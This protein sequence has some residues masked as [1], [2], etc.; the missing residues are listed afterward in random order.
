[1]VFRRLSVWLALAGVLLTIATL[2]GARDKPMAPAPMEPPPRNPYASTVAAAGI[3][4]AAN[5]NVKIAPPV[6]GLVTK[7]YVKVASQVHQGDVLFQLDDRELRAQLQT[8]TD[9][10]PSAAARIAEQD[11]RLRDVEDQ[12]QRLQSVKDRRAVS[13]DDV[14]RKWH[15]VEANKRELIRT[16]ADL[17]LAQTQRDEVQAIL[18]R[19]TIRAPRAGTIL[20]VNIRAGEYAMVNAIEA[21]ILLGDIETFQVRADIDEVNAPLVVPGSPAVAYLKGQ[22]K[23]AISLAFDRIEPYI[24]PKRSLTGDNRERVDTRVLQ[25]IY[26]FKKPSFPIY[27]GQQV[28]VFIERELKGVVPPTKEKGTTAEDMDHLTLQK[29]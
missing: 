4:E 29:E 22:T 9:S 12:L 23:H 2:W 15:E 8:K 18:E 10:L 3:I 28:D 27:V 14:Q 1:M 26:Q 17:R 20:Q 21:L 11:I 13:V 5:E 7:V 6:S 25:V 19:L 16:K 24:V